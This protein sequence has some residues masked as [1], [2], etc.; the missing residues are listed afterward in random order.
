MPDYRQNA[1]L[2]KH[3]NFGHV[4]TGAGWCYCGEL[5]DD[6]FILQVVIPYLHRSREAELQASY[7]RY[8]REGQQ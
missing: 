5:A 2:S 3:H 4:R 1:R 7:T 6:C 8:F